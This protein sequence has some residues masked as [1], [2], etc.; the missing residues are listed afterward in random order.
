MLFV[1]SFEFQSL[2]GQVVPCTRACLAEANLRIV[3]QSLLLRS[4]DIT[5]PSNASRAMN[6]SFSADQCN[7][8]CL[9]PRRRS[10]RSCFICATSF[11][12]SASIAPRSFNNVISSLLAAALG[13][14]SSAIFCFD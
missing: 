3:F 6:T 12:A 4:C 1:H 11:A 7:H 14:V 10:A 9:K 2:L 13:L 5:P 8:C